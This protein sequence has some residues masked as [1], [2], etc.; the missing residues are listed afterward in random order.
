[1]ALVGLVTM[2]LGASGVFA[3]LQDALDTIW[4]V[5]GKDVPGGLWAMLK[6]RF[7]SFSV[8]CGLAFL[9]LVSLF[10][11]LTL[12][13]LNGWLESKLPLGG[14][15]FHIANQVFSL[16]LTTGLFA[17]I[18]KVLPHKRPSWSDVWRGGVVTANPV[19]GREILDRSVL[20]LRRSRFRIW[21]RRSF[22]VLLIWIYYSTQILLFGAEFTQV[23]AHYHGSF[24]EPNAPKA[25][26]ET[27]QTHRQRELAR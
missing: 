21:G 4:E 10:L 20:W 8:V 27:D 6:D 24:C 15:G 2:A 19:H 7:I 1:M 25:C 3:Q 12:S 26:T 18:F 17:F 14:W 22:V 9:L 11:S 23:Y 13:A 5:Q 16:A